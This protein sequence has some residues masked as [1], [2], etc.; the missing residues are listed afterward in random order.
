MP[1]LARETQRATLSLP[2]VR[3]CF[4]DVRGGSSAAELAHPGPVHGDRNSV[5]GSA[6]SVL[7][8]CQ[9]GIH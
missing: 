3:S 1:H 6:Y 4:S 2:V 5:V 8:R 7:V 9:G